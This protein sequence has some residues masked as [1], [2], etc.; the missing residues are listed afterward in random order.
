MTGYGMVVGLVV[1]L[2]LSSTL[3]LAL[4]GWPA[5]GVE[6]RGPTHPAADGRWRVFAH[7]TNTLEDLARV[8]R[9]ATTHSRVVLG[10]EVDV[11][12]RS[13]RLWVA[14]DRGAD[15]PELNHY[16]EQVPD[17]MPVVLELK[18]SLATDDGVE[19]L[20][21]LLA[22]TR[23]AVPETTLCSFHPGILARIER[24]RAD[25]SLGDSPHVMPAVRTCLFSYLIRPRRYPLAR[26]WEGIARR[27]GRLGGPIPSTLE[28]DMVGIPWRSAAAEATALWS[29]SGVATIA[30]N[31]DGPRA[32]A[33][34][35]GSGIYGLFTDRPRL[36]AEL[37][38]ASSAD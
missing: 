30:G 10:V 29:E 24:L 5:H 38:A 17:E 19:A 34:L 23:S 26:L 9:L 20:L 8:T 21:E 13:G 12:F 35:G 37:V 2:G 15:G 32:V 6:L 18:T 33:K 11:Q 31:V 16:L 14:H 7:R 1:L 22:R 25:S 4:G 36:I 28:V 3:G 27:R